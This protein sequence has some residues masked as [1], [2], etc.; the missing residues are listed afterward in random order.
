[1]VPFNYDRADELTNPLSFPHL[2]T[3]AGLHVRLQKIENEEKECLQ[4]EN[5]SSFPHFTNIHVIAEMMEDVFSK[6]LDGQVFS[7]L[8]SSGFLFPRTFA[9]KEP[10]GHVL[11]FKP[12]FPKDLV[13]VLHKE[14]EALYK[15]FECFGCVNTYHEYKLSL[16]QIICHWLCGHLFHNKMEGGCPLCLHLEA[17]KGTD[18]A[19]VTVPITFY[20][21]S[22]KKMTKE[23]TSKNKRAPATKKKKVAGPK[24]PPPGANDA[25]HEPAEESSLSESDDDAASAPPTES[26]PPGEGGNPAQDASNPK[27]M[28]TLEKIQEGKRKI[29]E[30]CE[31][32]DD[33]LSPAKRKKQRR[34]TS[35]RAAAV[36]KARAKETKEPNSG[37]PSRKR[38]SDHQIGHA[39]YIADHLKSSAKSRYTAAIKLLKAEFEQEQFAQGTTEHTEFCLTDDIACNYVLSEVLEHQKMSHAAAYVHALFHSSK[40]F[41][42]LCNQWPK[43]FGFSGLAATIAENCL[44]FPLDLHVRLDG[45]DIVQRYLSLVHLMMKFPRYYFLKGAAPVGEQWQVVKRNRREE[46]VQFLLKDP[47]R[48][49]KGFARAVGYRCAYYTGSPT[50]FEPRWQNNQPYML[51][52][53]A[54]TADPEKADVEKVLNPGYERKTF[55]RYNNYE[56]ALD[57]EGFLTDD[58]LPDPPAPE[59]EKKEAAVS[60]GKDKKKK[61]NK[62]KDKKANNN[63]NNDSDDGNHVDNNGNYNDEQEDEIEIEIEDKEEDDDN[64]ND[65]SK[66][67]NNNI[68]DGDGYSGDDNDDNKDDD[69]NDGGE[70]GGNG[71]GVD[72]NEDGDEDDANKVA[73]Q[74]SDSDDSAVRDFMFSNMQVSR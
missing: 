25:P 67:A 34:S 16:F 30:D 40:Y 45:R 64:D 4:G 24:K 58:E 38:V 20:H 42:G 11:G 27:A 44:S 23:P 17:P 33:L 60:K 36:R 63:K 66:N 1:M 50:I 61:T 5:Y 9:V 54:E 29:A 37:T 8:N 3:I 15:H 10:S 6:D 43:L 46:Y 69:N 71:T 53:D 52:Y 74:D 62:G 21:H 48:R 56:R 68:T 72:D 28:V 12:K 65:D 22:P 55:Q 13:F 70:D 26:Q 73:D 39:A 7:L 57:G 59:D 49:R 35:V 18:P 41:A 32:G 31:A 51:G 2:S 14:N 19:E 47:F